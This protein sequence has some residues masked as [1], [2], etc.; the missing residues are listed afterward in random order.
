MNILSDQIHSLLLLHPA[1]L[2]V[3]PQVCVNIYDSDLHS[4]NNY[5]VLSMIVSVGA[6][7]A[8]SANAASSSSVQE[9]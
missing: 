2:I 8:V 6:A 4:D 5:N 1:H 7:A 3:A 9:R